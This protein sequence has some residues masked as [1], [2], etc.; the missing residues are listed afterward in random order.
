MKSLK[1]TR[2]TRTPAAISEIL[3]LQAVLDGHDMALQTLDQEISNTADSLGAHVS[4]PTGAHAASAISATPTGGLAGTTVAAQLG[5][6]EVGKATKNGEG[7]NYIAVDV[8]A[9]DAVTNG[10]NLLAAY[11]ASKLLTPNGAALAANNRAVVLIPPGRYD[12]GTTPLILDT[13]FVD[14]DGVSGDP[15]HVLITSA[16]TATNSGTIVQSANDIRVR[17]V[18]VQ[19]TASTRQ[20]YDNSDASAYAPQ[21]AYALTVWEDVTFDDNNSSWSMR[22]GVEYSGTFVG[23]TGGDYSFGGSLGGGSASGTFTNCTGGDYSFGGSLGGGSASG[24]FTGCT[25]G[26]SAFGGYGSASG[27]FTNCTGGDDGAFGGYGHASGTFTNCT[28]GSL[29]FGGYGGTASGTFTRCT[30]GDYAFGGD[31]SGTASGTFTNCTGG[32]G[33]FG[34]FGG[35]LSGKLYFCRLTSGSFE[36]VSGSGQTRYCLDGTNTANNQG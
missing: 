21:G 34:G 23:C 11:A 7:V 4:N 28:G 29:A 31:S 19:N 13:Q 2:S 33:S 27:T 14:L 10:A 18:T 17:A 12:L 32:N 26:H 20:N 15:K 16:V 22:H 3:G 9:D 36:T 30:G 6:L 24:T 1:I 8:S 35:T 25:G 5:E